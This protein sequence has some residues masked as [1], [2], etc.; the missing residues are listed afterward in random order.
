MPNDEERIIRNFQIKGYSDSEWDSI[1]KKCRELELI[2]NIH[3][4]VKIL[5]RQFLNDEFIFEFNKERQK[6]VLS[7][8]KK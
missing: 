4:L 2:G 8:I 6:I 7:E 5:L 3:N 1:K